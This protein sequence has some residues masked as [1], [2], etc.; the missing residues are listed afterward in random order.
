MEIVGAVGHEPQCG[1]ARHGL[2]VYCIAA[3]AEF[4]LRSGALAPGAADYFPEWFLSPL[5]AVVHLLHLTGRM[6]CRSVC[7]VVW[8]H[9]QSVAR[10]SGLFGSGVKPPRA[11]VPKVLR[12]PDWL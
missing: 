2:C 9:P 3:G 10:W 8:S 12:D 5:S 1:D 6:W 4:L 11:R 7:L